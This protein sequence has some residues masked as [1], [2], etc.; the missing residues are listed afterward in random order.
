MYLI[1]SLKACCE[2][3]GTYGIHV[4]S[5]KKKKKFGESSRSNI[6]EAFALNVVLKG[7]QMT[8]TDLRR[9]P[10]REGQT[11]AQTIEGYV[12]DHQ[13]GTSLLCWNPTFHVVLIFR[14]RAKIL[15]RYIVHKTHRLSH[16]C[17]TSI[18]PPVALKSP[19]TERH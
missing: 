19:S 3:D 4:N 2:P 1:M 18:H 5:Q 17:S 13:C 12:A 7:S 8:D 15:T 9:E 10:E 6:P 14:L 16:S 11:D